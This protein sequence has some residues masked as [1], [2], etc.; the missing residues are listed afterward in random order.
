MLGVGQAHTVLVKVRHEHDC[1]VLATLRDVEVIERVVRAT[2]GVG[3]D[4][5]E[6]L[7]A[8]IKGGG[9]RV[10]A[11]AAATDAIARFEHDPAQSERCQ[12][13]AGAETASAG[14]HYDD[15]EIA[16]IIATGS[17]SG[18]ARQRVASEGIGHCPG[19]HA[20]HE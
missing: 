10:V 9:E 14:A 8:K 1:L 20:P 2:K 17:R 16:G 15:V 3:H 12:L 5:L 6:E 18:L 13:L 7:A 4:L 11:V 19:S